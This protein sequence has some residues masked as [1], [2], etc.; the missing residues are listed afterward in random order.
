[1]PTRYFLLAIR[2]NAEGGK[3]VEGN[4]PI[5]T[6]SKLSAGL[7]DLSKEQYCQNLRKQGI[8]CEASQAMILAVIPLEE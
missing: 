1:M 6:Q 7:F 2:V 5:E 4:F 3:I 8:R